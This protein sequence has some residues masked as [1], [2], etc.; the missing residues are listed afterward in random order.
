MSFAIITFR[1]YT[2]FIKTLL[3]KSHLAYI[4]SRYNYKDNFLQ[5][6]RFEDIGNQYQI[7]KFFVTKGFMNT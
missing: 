1:I 7:N 2:F 3:K 4:G 6:S 5:F